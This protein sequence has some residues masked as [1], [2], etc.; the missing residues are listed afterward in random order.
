MMVV[1]V[2]VRRDGFCSRVTRGYLG[3]VLVGRRTGR[4]V[5]CT[6]GVPHGGGD[7]GGGDERCG[8]HFGDEFGVGGGGALGDGVGRGGAGVMKYDDI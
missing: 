1:V 6:V 4:A 2:V 5:E 7:S 3:R 8:L